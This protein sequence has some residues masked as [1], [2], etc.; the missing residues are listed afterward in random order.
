MRHPSESGESCGVLQHLVGQYS[1]IGHA[2]S[3]YR[4]VENE[5]AACTKHLFCVKEI[6]YRYIGNHKSRESPLVAQ[7]LREE[8][9]AAA[10]PFGSETA[11]RSHGCGCVADLDGELEGFEINLAQSLLACPDAET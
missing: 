5:V 9:V 7:A 3:V 4:T 11:E 8:S 10:G 1:G 6:V 2:E